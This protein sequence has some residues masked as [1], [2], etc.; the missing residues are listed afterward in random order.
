MKKYGIFY[1]ST[2]GATEDVAHRLAKVM[3]ID[4][5]DVHN[6]ADT[7]PDAVADYETLILG[8]STWG[9]GDLQDD[10]YDFL[11]GLKVLTLSDKKIAIFGVGDENM[12]DTF[13]NAVAKI[14]NGLQETGADFIGEFNTDGYHFER[15]E[16]ARGGE[17]LGLLLDE[18]NHPE[19]TD[20]RI[21]EWAAQISK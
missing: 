4:S 14:Y 3:N 2:T 10:W 1:G 13:C 8:S 9:S 19:L 16:A 17:A 20:E 6:V 15:S 12:S 21:T 18:T 11:T 5:S 7:A